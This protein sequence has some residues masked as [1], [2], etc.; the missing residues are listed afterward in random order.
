MRPILV[1]ALL[2][3][4]VVH[5]PA[6]ASRACPFVAD[7]RGDAHAGTEWD[8]TTGSVQSLDVLSADL[9]TSPTSLVAVIR[10]D[11][12]D[13]TEPTTPLGTGYV[14]EFTTPSEHGGLEPHALYAASKP[15]GDLVGGWGD[16]PWGSFVPGGSATVRYVATDHSFRVTVSFGSNPRALPWGRGT[17]VIGNMHVTSVRTIAAI[18]D[19]LPNTQ[20][21]Y[22]QSVDEAS[23]PIAYRGGSRACIGVTA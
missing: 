13:A 2:G 6:M 1:A 11:G 5:A 20:P 12:F 10:L 18:E 9:A 4:I 21:F 8:G 19:G 14:F 23:G 22:G 3:V 16:G 17:T 7:P 15:T